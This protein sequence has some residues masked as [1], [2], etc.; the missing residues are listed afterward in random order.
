MSG[1]RFAGNKYGMVFSIDIMMALII[2]TVILGVSADAMDIV[3]SKMEDYSYGNSLE[4]IAQAGADMLVKT[5]GNPENWEKFPDVN[6]VT[7]GLSDLEINKKTHSNVISMVKIKRL[8]E[9]YD[10]LINGNVIPSHCK[11]TLVIYPVDQS[12]EPINVKDIGE[13]DSSS[14][15]FVE[16]RTVLC[17]YLNTTEMVFINARDQSLLSS[18]NQ[19]GDECPHGEGTG[20]QSHE[21]VDY[22]NREAG[23]VCYPLRVTDGMFNSTDF[24]LITDPASIEDPVAMWIIDR[25]ENRTEYTQLFQNKPILLNGMIEGIMGNNSTAVLWLHVYSSGNP[26][27]A[28]NTHLAAFPKGTPPENVKVQYLTPQPCYFVFKVWV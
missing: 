28:F 24:Y 21:K 10:K 6:G 14:E 2:I 15:V 3:G 8:E 1:D 4:R 9:N 12:L 11:S 16:N 23:W 19:F 20:S 25:P 5:P 7:P 27:K 17:N 22:K 26:D 13:N 18:Q